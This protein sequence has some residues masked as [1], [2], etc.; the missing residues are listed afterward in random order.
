MDTSSQP[1]TIAHN[2]HGMTSNS[3]TNHNF[4]FTSL[5]LYVMLLHGQ[6]PQA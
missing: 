5:A 2:N 1:Y 3:D 4:W 6:V